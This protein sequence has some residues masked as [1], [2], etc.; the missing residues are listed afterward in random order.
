MLDIVMMRSSRWGWLACCML[1]LPGCDRLPAAAQ[2]GGERPPTQFALG[3]NLTMPTYYSGEPAFTNL[4]TG[5][6][7]RLGWQDVKPGSVDAPGNITVE[8][9]QKAQR[10]LTAPMAVLTG[11]GATIVCTWQGKGDVSIQGAK[12]KDALGDHSWEFFWPGTAGPTDKLVWLELSSS[13]GSDPLRNFDC[14]E[15]GVARGEV[16]SAEFLES[17]KPFG[18]LRFMDWSAVNGNPKQVSWS[19][20]TRADSIDQV[21]A[22]GGVALEHM[23]ALSNRMDADPWFNVPWNADE[24]YVRRMA[25]MVHDGIPAHRHVYAELSN[26]VWNYSFGVTRQ[27]QEEGEA[28]KLAPGDGFKSALL[29]YAEKTRWAMRIWAQVFADRPGQLVRVAATQGDNP[30]T[31]TVV[32]GEAKLAADVDAL[33]VAPYFGADLFADG[34]QKGV[35]DTAVLLNVLAGKAKQTQTGYTTKNAEVARQYGKRLIAYE[36]GQHVV[37]E[38][39]L[40]LVAQLNRSDAMYG[41]YKSYIGDWKAQINDTMVLYNSTGPISV[42]G[43]WG[44]REYAGQPLAETP[45]RRAAI[46][47]GRYPKIGASKGA[48]AKSPSAMKQPH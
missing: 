19:T 4:L 20:R 15:K 37:G 44:L 39:N 7:W 48:A 28:A 6:G 3:V 8:T 43:A 23:I 26:E 16:F 25:Q 5:S 36:A 42:W 45:K 32:L 1:A 31:A 2:F 40:G 21:E 29:R 27:A 47:F 41:I 24:D 38:G 34:Q 46:E 11:K 30:W 10:I 14:R 17:M 33:A 9:G 35:T 18:V 22:P 13:S 12:S